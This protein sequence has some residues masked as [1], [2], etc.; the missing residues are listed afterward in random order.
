MRFISQF[1]FSTRS[2]IGLFAAPF[3]LLAFRAAVGADVDLKEGNKGNIKSSHIAESGSVSSHIA[4]AR[5]NVQEK[6]NSNISAD[7]IFAHLAKITPGR[8]GEFESSFYLNVDKKT[9]VAELR[10]WES[11]PSESIVLAKFQVAFGK[12]KGDK[13]KQ[14][15]NKT[16][17]GIYFAKSH[18]KSGIPEE[19]YGP[20][21]IPLDFP[22]PIDDMEN[23]TGY[24]IWLHGAGNDERIGKVNVTEGCVAFYNNDILKVKNW[25]DPY[26]AAV[27]I[28][29]DASTVNSAKAV[30]SLKVA[31]E[32]W[33]TAWDA[34]NIKDY[35]EAYHPDFKLGMKNLRGFSSYK[36]RIFKSYKD[37]KVTAFDVKYLT[38]DKYAVTAFNQDFKGDKRYV[39]K[40]SKILYWLNDG[41]KWKIAREEFSSRFFKPMKFKK[42]SVVKILKDM[43]IA[44]SSGKLSETNY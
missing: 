36:K 31:F 12:A 41:G 4:V 25:I 15:D 24:G 37:M 18:I 1:N 32:K 39:S 17:E 33:L 34:D 11:S 6:L 22:N 10:S 21:S 27:V 35:L 5:A 42:Q 9:R 13:M 30:A 28:S 44:N 43:N 23:K 29:E 14:G 7:K 40:G 8:E 38:H 20:Y 2:K 19:K 16:P 26:Q 3:I